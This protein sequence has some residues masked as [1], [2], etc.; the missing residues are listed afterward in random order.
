MDQNRTLSSE[1]G[2]T[3]S[4]AQNNNGRMF[5]TRLLDRLRII[6]NDGSTVLFFECSNIQRSCRCQIFLNYYF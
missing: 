4:V 1:V 6:Y 3:M 5:H 2:A